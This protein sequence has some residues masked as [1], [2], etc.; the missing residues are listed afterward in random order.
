MHFIQQHNYMNIIM[1]VTNHYDTETEIC[2]SMTF[3]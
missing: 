2:D 1:L 3:L